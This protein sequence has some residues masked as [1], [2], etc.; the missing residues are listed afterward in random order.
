MARLTARGGV[1]LI[2]N[3]PTFLRAGEMHYF[4][5][6]REVWLSSLAKLKEAGLNTISTYIPWIW[7]EVEEGHFDFVGKTHPQRDLVGFIEACRQTD[8]YLIVRPGPFIYAEYR[9][10]GH[11]LWL[12][13]HYP[14]TVAKR[15][16]GQPDRASYYFNHSV[17][18][19]TYLSKVEKWYERLIGILKPYCHDPI[20]MFQID[21]ETGA[22][23]TN[24]LGGLDFNPDTVERYRHFLED[25]YSDISELNSVWGTS[26]PAFST[27]LPPK[28]PFGHTEA[29]DWQMFLEDWVAKYLHYLRQ[30]TYRLGLDL[31][32]SINEPADFLSP[33]NPGLKA[34]VATVHGFDSYVKSSGGQ[35]TAD[36]P[37]SSSRHPVLFQAYAGEEQPLAALEMGCG[38]FDHRAKV[39][40]ELTLQSMMAAIAHGVKGINL[41]NVQN[42]AEPN[43]PRYRFQ[44]LLEDDGSVLPRYDVVSQ[45]EHFIADYEEGLLAS[46]EVFDPIAYLSYF[47]NHR[48]IPEYYILGQRIVDPSRG[49]AFLGQFGLYGL[50]LTCGYNPRIVDLERAT[51]KDLSQF[52]V[53]I[54]LSDGFLDEDSYTKLLNYVKSGGHLITTPLSTR[55]DLSGKRLPGSELY[56]CRQVGEKWLD[57]FRIL[58]Y[59]GWH[60]LVKYNLVARP[61]IK[62]RLETSLHIVDNIEPILVGQRAPVKGALVETPEGMKLRTDCFVSF[63]E[64][65]AKSLLDYQGKTVCYQTAVG[66]GTSIVLGTLLAGCYA[67]SRYYTLFPEERLDL[68]EYLSALMSGL[69]VRPRFTT[70]M[71]IE[72]VARRLF[73]G[74]LLFVINRLGE[75]EGSIVLQDRLSLGLGQHSFAAQQLFAY[76]GSSVRMDRRSDLY[77]QLGADDVLVLRLFQD[78]R[79]SNWNIIDE[80]G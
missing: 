78:T 70:D 19:P 36:F 13:E 21:N 54:F 34:P 48:F 16:D 47:P 4:R 41:Y 23:Y 14:E 40:N 62:G 59:L 67:T 39:S 77:V 68:R 53:V 24:A 75:Q 49:L 9:G 12:G 80:K 30:L 66:N 33:V 32:L 65:G 15:A 1:F 22:M 51:L 5:I 43:G 76:K 57:R 38:W 64:D 25:K 28:R 35:Y 44:G 45:V 37:F 8:L 11:P 71:E 72:I 20:I 29:V 50:L 79:T 17:L 58:A 52:K 73:D 63:Y 18:H 2:D 74:C 42:G 31:P 6:K 3:R 10:F 61:Q 7:H 46:Q 27:I 55:C 26:H 56:P 60:W 69:G